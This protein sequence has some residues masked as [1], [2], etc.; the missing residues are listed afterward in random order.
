MLSFFLHIV[1]RKIK[2]ASRLTR[3]WHIPDKV[4]GPGDHD[5]AGGALLPR[6]LPKVGHRRLGRP[7]GHDVRLRLNQ[8]LQSTRRTLRYY[9]GHTQYIPDI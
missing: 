1:L 3:V 6:H 8:T 7:L 9:A 4:K 2:P 5:D